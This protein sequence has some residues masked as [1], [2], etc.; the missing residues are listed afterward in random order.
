MRTC[1]KVF[2]A[3]RYVEA[4]RDYLNLQIRPGIHELTTIKVLTIP[5]LTG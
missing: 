2:V 1:L 5:V 3:F 4:A